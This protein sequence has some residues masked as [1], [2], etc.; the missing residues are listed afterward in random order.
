MDVKAEFLAEM[1]H[2]IDE[3]KRV[4]AQIEANAYNVKLNQNPDEVTLAQ[5]FIHAQIGQIR[6]ILKGMNN[7]SY[8]YGRLFVKKCKEQDKQQ[9]K[10]T[11]KNET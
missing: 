7:R 9:I 6:Q 2:H 10:G 5:S 3:L 8:Y 4:L 11:A 1:D